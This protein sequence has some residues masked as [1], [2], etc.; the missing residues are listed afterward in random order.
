MSTVYLQDGALY[1][2]CLRH[3]RARHRLFYDERHGGADPDGRWFQEQSDWVVGIRCKAHSCH[4][5]II[6]SLKPYSS[7]EISDSAHIALASLLNCSSAIL[8]RVDVFLRSCIV[9]GESPG[10]SGDIAAFW[11]ALEVTPAML[12]LFLE[13]DPMFSEGRFIVASRLQHDPECYSKVATVVT[14]CLRWNLWSD[15]R[16][17]KASKSGRFYLR[18]LCVGIDQLFKICIGDPSCSNYLLTG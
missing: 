12:P 10:N 8:Q 3:C 1:E 7:K 4:N 9:F 5:S 17:V 13:V 18:S 15:T 14:C 16:W 11:T 6:W 2:A